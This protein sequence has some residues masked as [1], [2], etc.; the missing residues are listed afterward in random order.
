LP[1]AADSVGVALSRRRVPKH[2]RSRADDVS[3]AA[4]F[5]IEIGFVNRAGSMICA[6]LAAA[7]PDESDGS[8]CT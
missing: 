7:D 6:G 2:V 3:S 8:G 1:N 5:Q 4:I